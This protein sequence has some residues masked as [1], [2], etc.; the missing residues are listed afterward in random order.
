[1]EG[2][3]GQLGARDTEVETAVERSLPRRIES[4]SRFLLETLHRSLDGESGGP[5]L[6]TFGMQLL[7]EMRCSVGKKAGI[8][9]ASKTQTKRGQVFQLEL[10]SD[11]RTGDQSLAEILQSSLSNSS[12]IRAWFDAEVKYTTVLQRRVV[13]SLPEVMVVACGFSNGGADGRGMAE[14]PAL[15]R[16][17]AVDVRV[18]DTVDHEIR[19]SQA[20]TLEELIASSSSIS[21]S[22]TSSCGPPTTTDAAKSYCVLYELTAVVSHIRDPDEAPG[23]HGRPPEGHLVAEIRVPKALLQRNG[24]C[25]VTVEDSLCKRED[26]DE[27]ATG[28]AQG[29]TALQ[30]QQSKE[31]SSTEDWVLFNDFRV[32]RVTWTDVASSL[33]GHKRPCLLVYTKRR[34]LYPEKEASVVPVPENEPKTGIPKPSPS[35]QPTPVLDPDGFLRLCRLPSLVRFG[36]AVGI[37]F[38]CLNNNPECI[39]TLYHR[40][41]SLG[42]TSWGASPDLHSPRRPGTAQT[43]NACGP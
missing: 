6:A 34:V 5:V 11:S 38:L 7:T 33:D 9:A 21:S 26:V 30:Q 23:P 3:S 37:C 28:L 4:L 42:C 25:E 29:S 39:S 1:M 14:F 15:S 12:T 8:D 22:S 13:T 20:D 43:R 31:I 16:A 2:V 27:Q 17:V 18:D 32:E 41:F 35:F 36:G 19:V 40:Q 24:A 10:G